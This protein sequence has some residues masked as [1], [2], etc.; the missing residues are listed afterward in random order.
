MVKVLFSIKLTAF[1]V[2]GGAYMKLRQKGPR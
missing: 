2:S 1:Q